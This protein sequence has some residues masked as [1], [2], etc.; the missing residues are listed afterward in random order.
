M[1][2]LHEAHCPVLVVQGGLERLLEPSAAH[3]TAVL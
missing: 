3:E 1:T 2:V